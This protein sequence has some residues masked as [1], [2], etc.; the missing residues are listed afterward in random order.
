MS[1]IGIEMRKKV[2]FFNKEKNNRDEQEK[3]N[4]IRVAVALRE[5]VT[6]D[7]N[8]TRVKCLSAGETYDQ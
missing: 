3:V 4:G 8:K 2:F 7:K 1:M 5:N 6:M